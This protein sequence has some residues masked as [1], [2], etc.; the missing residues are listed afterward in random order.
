MGRD[1][2]LARLADL[3]DGARE[4]TSGAL[5]LSGEA[6]IGKTALLGAAAGLAA[7]FR[8]VRTRGVEAE[9]QLAHAGLLEVLSPLRD[10]L[11]DLP[12]RQ[13]AALAGA[14]GWE[15]STVPADRF[16]VCAATVSL[17]AAAAERAPVLVVVDDVQWVDR[18]S[19]AALNFAA[20]RLGDDRVCVLLAGRPATRVD[21]VATLVLS[22]LDP[23]Q[24][25]ALVGEAIA[26]PVLQGLVSATGG[27]PLGLLES[28]RA[29]TDAQ[30]HGTAPLPDHLPLGERLLHQFADDLAGLAPAAR[31]AVL[32]LALDRSHGAATVAEALHREGL[33][34][35][36][37]LEEALDHGILVRDTSGLRFRHPLLRSA[38]LTGVPAGERRSAHLTLAAA[39]P[40]G[41][42]D[43]ARAWHRAS[44]ATAPDPALCEELARLAAATRARQGHAA[45]SAALERAAALA[46]RPERAAGLLAESAA[47]AF[48]AGDA[49]R[50]RLLVD[51]VLRE[52]AAPPAAR[53]RAYL[54][55]GTLEQYAG[56]VPRAVE[57]LA[58]A[59]ELV[60]GSARVPALAELALCRFR[61][62]DLDGIRA[63]ADGVRACA[64]PADPWQELVADFTG[65]LAGFLEGDVA[66]GADLLGSVVDRGLGPLRDDLRSFLF[67]ALAA[68]FLGDVHRVVA[69]GVHHRHLM[70]AREQGALGI[71]VPSLAIM[72]AGL[73]WTG[74]HRAA[75]ADA[76]EALELADMLGY[77]ADAAV[78]AE[79]LAWQSAA[80]GLHEDA[81]AALVRA[82]A[83]T[84]R[85][86]TTAVAAH[87][88]LTA[89][90][91]ALCRDDP[92]EVVALLEPRL[93][94]DGGVGAMGEPLG[95]APDLVEAYVA[96]GRAADA[97]ELAARL[98]AVTPE[99]APAHL[100]AL[101]A[102]AR[103]LAATEDAE[104]FAAFEEAL[105]LHEQAPDAFEA[106]RTRLAHGSRL[107]RAGRRVD[108]REPLRQAQG[109]FAAM[110][111]SAWADRAGHELA[112]TG[113]QRQPRT[114]GAEP[115]TSQETRVALH[116]ARG[117]SNRDIAAALF[118]SPRTVERHLGSV[119]RK[120]G[121]RSR[122]ELAAAP[123]RGDL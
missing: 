103:A 14:F 84:D 106:A 30:R 29:L 20:R 118:L 72:A 85:A 74:D 87:Q 81:R 39:L 93:A 32:L 41:E 7:G 67:V 92:A 17:L 99:A 86:G 49:E 35:A 121:L 59:A 96:T 52:P 109:A 70:R 31:R 78:A 25:A 107:R 1:A 58:A 57:L 27:N 71:L 28:A 18:E 51:R 33:V 44:A 101:A 46:G 48:V 100:R 11:D 80:R 36:D 77:A 89:A 122:T 2:E 53:G 76:G 56:S 21:G 108:A 40:E 90:F 45:S 16:L 83:L 116:A 10:C 66:T 8:C 120:R 75:F 82:R 91:C 50:T 61:V 15:P 79:Q 42:D 95:V 123:G 24:A 62:G 4:G 6:G 9:M 115:L 22:G 63:C 114:H 34:A 47:D 111:L 119:F 38:V 102:R 65:G 110:D 64:D 19:T 113:Q 55:L 3:L 37:A 68:A 117:L 98:A 43:W 104:A 88:T 112:A 97:R 69:S 60:D 13:A 5:L 73:A 105:A 54:T 94:V 12:E 26:G 23:E